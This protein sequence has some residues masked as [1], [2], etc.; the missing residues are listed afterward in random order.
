MGSL[1]QEEVGWDGCS[2]QTGEREPQ[3][4]GGELPSASHHT[5]ARAFAA[6]HA[7]LCHPPLL[8]SMPHMHTHAQGVNVLQS[9]GFFKAGDSAEILQVGVRP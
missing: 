5:S 8:T 9:L 3:D 7:P 1:K 4:S 6:S 2:L